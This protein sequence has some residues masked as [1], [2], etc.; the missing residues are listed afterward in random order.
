MNNYTIRS[1]IR[2]GTNRFKRSV[3][4]LGFFALGRALQSASRI[5]SEVKQEV[6]A[7]P[8]GF[9]FSMNVMPNGPDLVM[10]KR[11]GIMRLS[12]F[13]RKKDADLIVEIKNL[14]TAFKMITTQVGAHH[15]YAQHKIGVIGNVADS[16]RLIR[17][18]YVAEGYLFPKL[19]NKN[20]LKQSP[21]MN[22]KKHLNRLHIY[23]LG[24]FLGK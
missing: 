7:W 4:S 21:E 24:L 20:V 1:N 23:T 18:I 5:D 8:E 22:L 3:V 15:V 19:L 9:S 13:E 16:M 11:S 17:M 2:P 6:E 12:G 14:D 10:K